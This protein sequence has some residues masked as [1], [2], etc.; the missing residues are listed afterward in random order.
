MQK[1]VRQLMPLEVEENLLRSCTHNCKHMPSKASMELGKH[2][3]LWK[4]VVNPSQN[5]TPNFI[6][7]G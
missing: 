5:V 6:L 3:D 4:K 7:V 1:L 2:D